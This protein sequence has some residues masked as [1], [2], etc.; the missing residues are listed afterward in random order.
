MARWFDGSSKS[1]P[2]KARIQSLPMRR[3]VF[4]Q[5]RFELRR[6]GL[7]FSLVV[8]G[9]EAALFRSRGHFDAG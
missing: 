3:E 1:L 6:S 4:V 8:T 5:S 7:C 9:A 2:V